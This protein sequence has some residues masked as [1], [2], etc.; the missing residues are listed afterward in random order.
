[1]GHCWPGNPVCPYG[2][3]STDIDANSEMWAFFEQ[4]A[5]P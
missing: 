4:F 3:A 2:A 1:M 5:L